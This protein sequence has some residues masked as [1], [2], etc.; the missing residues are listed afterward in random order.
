MEYLFAPSPV[1]L[2]ST[3]RARAS[4]KFNLT[5][6]DVKLDWPA[7]FKFIHAY[8][9]KSP[10]PRHTMQGDTREMETRGTNGTC[11]SVVTIRP[12]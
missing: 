8:L 4:F 12:K 11:T 3:G 6:A 1:T 2:R 7:V 10:L 5:N 9:F